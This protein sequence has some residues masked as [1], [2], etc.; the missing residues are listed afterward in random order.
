MGYA[1]KIKRM[2]DL[3]LERE[4]SEMTKNIELSH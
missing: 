2:T 1:D 4:T 3:I